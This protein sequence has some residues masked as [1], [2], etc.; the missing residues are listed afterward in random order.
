MPGEARNTRPG[1]AVGAAEVKETKRRGRYRRRP[2]TIGGNEYI[3][4][5]Y[6][7]FRQIKAAGGW[8]SALDW[9]W[10][11]RRF[12]PDCEYGVW[13]NAYV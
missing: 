4:R 5:R 11:R 3:T 6:G 8:R 13:G 12:H 9:I 7:K 10:F 1:A 2:A